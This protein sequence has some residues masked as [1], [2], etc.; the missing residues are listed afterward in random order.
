MPRAVPVSVHALC[1]V[2]VAAHMPPDRSVCY[3]AACGKVPT[4]HP[5]C[6]G[7]ARQR[8]WYQNCGRCMQRLL[9]RGSCRVVRAPAQALLLEDAFGRGFQAQCQAWGVSGCAPLQHCC[10]AHPPGAWLGTRG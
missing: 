9:A 1:T 5:K 7:Q 4:S 6:S 2:P 8:T 3:S 10:E